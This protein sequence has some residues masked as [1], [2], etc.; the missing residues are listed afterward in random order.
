[1]GY[2]VRDFGIPKCGCKAENA[3]FLQ[4]SSKSS[5]LLICLSDT[6]LAWEGV[7]FD[8]DIRAES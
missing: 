7:S 2:R 3:S 5:N 8:G 4:H 1:L 6:Y